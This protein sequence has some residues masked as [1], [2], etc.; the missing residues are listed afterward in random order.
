MY[1]NQTNFASWNEAALL[2]D[3][4]VGQLQFVARK[5]GLTSE[6]EFVN[7]ERISLTRGEDCAMSQAD[8]G[9]LNCS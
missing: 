3:D 6:S 9:E 5:V 8:S 4:G 1:R 7:I 2:L